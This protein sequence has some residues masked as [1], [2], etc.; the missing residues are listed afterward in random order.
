VSA[1]VALAFAALVQWTPLEEHSFY[2]KR[3]ATVA[4][5]ES[6]AE[7]IAEVVATAEGARVE[8]AELE[9][10]LL[11]SIASAE[12]HLARDV[13]ECRRGGPSWT[14]WQVSTHR[15]FV[16]RDR[17]NAA[18]VALYRIRESWAVCGSATPA[19]RLSFY[20]SGSCDRGHAA[21]RYRAARALDAWQEIRRRRPDLVM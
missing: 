18:R 7:D 12:S 13:D 20:A 9:A 5:Y 15:A 6:V 3:S 2:E 11:A 19:L 8:S 14:L 17:R 16:C 10:L 4:R 21:S 1:L